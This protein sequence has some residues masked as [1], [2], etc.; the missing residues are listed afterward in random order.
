MRIIVLFVTLLTMSCVD[1]S[2]TV[3]IQEPTQTKEQLIAMLDTIWTSEQQP[4]TMR[5]SMMEI[6]GVDSKEANKYQLI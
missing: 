5:D 2:K 6:Y 1:K 3:E 4:I